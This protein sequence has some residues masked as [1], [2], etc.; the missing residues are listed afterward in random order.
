MV[1]LLVILLWISHTSLRLC[2]PQ[3]QM[4]IAIVLE[5]VAA[6]RAVNRCRCLRGGGNGGHQSEN[7]LPLETKRRRADDGNQT[8]IGDRRERADASFPF[9][10]R[11]PPPFTQNI[12]EERGGGNE[13]GA[14]SA[15]DDAAE[16]AAQR[17]AA[18][19]T[20]RAAA[21]AREMA[22]QEGWSL[23]S[24]DSDST[25]RSQSPLPLLR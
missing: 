22:A 25:S 24:G 14:R 17:A 12:A 2:K 6:L 10:L 11:S 19:T 13:E 7:N 20:A 1:R 3:M 4:H 23:S 5:H 9:F 16:A 18:T 21:A 8:E 15:E